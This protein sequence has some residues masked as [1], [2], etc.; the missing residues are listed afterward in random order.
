MV[1]VSGLAA[2]AGGNDPNAS[3]FTSA[4]LPTMTPT[5]DDSLGSSGVV[6]TEASASSG[7]LDEST[8][9]LPTTGEGSGST[10][11]TDTTG[12]PDDS[13][14]A[15]EGGCVEGTPDC[16]CQRDNTCNDGLVC[17]DGLCVAEALAVCGDGILSGDEEC[18]AGEDNGDDQQCKSDCTNQVCGDGFVGPG[19]A[20]DDGN[21]VD[22]DACSNACVPAECGDMVVQQG[23]ECD[24]GNMDNN[25]GCITCKLAVC[26]DTHVY[27]G[28]EECDD[29]N[30]V[31]GDGCSADC[32]IEAPKCGGNFTTG[33]CLQT[34]TK[35]QFTR[36]ESVANNNKTCNNPLIKYGTVENGIPASHG[37][38][39]FNLWC[40][41]LGFAGFSGQ[42]SYGNRPCLAP[43]G[44]LFGCTSYDEVTWHWCD[45]QDGFWYN[46]QL[47]YHT[48][49]D[50]QQITSITCQ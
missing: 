6:A 41:Q 46:Q 38:N 42:V 12:T 5:M 8:G 4:A 35:D 27:E 45:W 15:G 23:E 32:K 14:S 47:N 18:D 17:E 3:G 19:E 11:T 2:C 50:G 7:D 10:T 48:C 24:D 13:T 16:P 9:E 36:C 28:V 31:N 34:G 44:R 22:D 1:G 25:D 37:G 33:W 39:N 20:C 21:D 49:N 30:Q 43:Q 29:G 26:G 40:Q